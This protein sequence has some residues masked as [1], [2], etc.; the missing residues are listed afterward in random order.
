[1]PFFFIV[2]VWLLFIGVG[3]LCV[4]SSRVRFLSAYL[5]LG[6]TM[7]LL[8]SF[9]VSLSLL[10]LGARLLGGTS[11]AWISLIAYLFGIVAG[12]AIGIVAGLMLARVL[13]RRLGWA[14]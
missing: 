13:N 10:M 6:S 7:G 5:V 9:V 1:V 2:P 14:R 8:F 4:F 12:G 11:A 3:T